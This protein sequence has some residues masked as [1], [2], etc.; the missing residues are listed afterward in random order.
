MDS[1]QYL[2]TQGNGLVMICE[3]NY[4]EMDHDFKDV[5]GVNVAQVLETW[6]VNLIFKNKGSYQQLDRVII[7]PKFVTYGINWYALSEQYG[8]G[9]GSWVN[10]LHCLFQKLH[11]YVPN[12][13]A[14]FSEEVSNGESKY[15][16]GSK[17]QIHPRGKRCWVDLADR[18]TAWISKTEQTAHEFL[19]NGLFTENDVHEHFYGCLKK[20]Y[21]Q[22]Y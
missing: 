12:V 11:T 8:P 2:H 1:I 16:G 7:D 5:H 4:G 15:T 22:S 13:L 10:G 17:V 18:H 20:P 19:Q 6:G 9:S 14:I 21:R 3:E